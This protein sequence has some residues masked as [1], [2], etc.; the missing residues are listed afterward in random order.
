[1]MLWSLIHFRH[2]IDYNSFHHFFPKFFLVILNISWPWMNTLFFTNPYFFGNLKLMW[3]T[4]ITSVKCLVYTMMCEAHVCWLMEGTKTLSDQLCLI[5]SNSEMKRATHNV[6]H[7]TRLPL[8][9]VTYN[10]CETE[11]TAVA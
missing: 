5:Y 11:P 8:N 10:S 1:M 3:R 2:Q 7:S 9:V 4:I 6:A